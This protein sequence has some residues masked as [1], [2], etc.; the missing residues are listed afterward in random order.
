MTNKQI[1]LEGAGDKP[2]VLLLHS[3]ADSGELMQPLAAQIQQAGY[4]VY[5]PT[6][7]GHATGTF[8][9]I[10]EQDM[11]QWRQDGEQ[12]LEELRTK[13]HPQIVA[14]GLSLGGLVA[15]DLMVNHPDLS[16]L[17]TI[18]APML[19]DIKESRVPLF[20]RQKFYQS[21]EHTPTVQDRDDA[22]HIF[23]R[24]DD[25][26]GGINQWMDEVFPALFNITRPVLITQGQADEVIDPKLAGRFQRSLRAANP[27]SLKTY[28]EGTHYLVQPP[29]LDEL[30][31][32]IIGF[33]NELS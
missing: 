30:A 19:G 8:L 21:L 13:G 32:D 23:D 6:F 33:L 1:Y 24:L 17:I 16:G 15:V 5:V 7:T 27:L 11:M 4:S 12:F 26:L 10:F 25:I 28:S 18:A 2:A 14:A 29:V 9:D 20:M 3:L 31:G 22:Q